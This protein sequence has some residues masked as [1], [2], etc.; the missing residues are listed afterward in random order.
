VIEAVEGVTA[1]GITSRTISKAE[2][3]ADIF[4][5]NQVYDS[6]DGLTE[7]CVPDAIMVLVSANQI[8]EVTEKLI[9]IGIPFFVEKPPGLVPDQT[10]TLAELAD[11]HGTKNMVG[12]NRRYYSSFHQGLRIIE[13]HGGLL[14]LAVEGHE[15]FWNVAGGDL[16]EEIRA[17][18]I[19]CNSTHTVDLLRF[20]GGEIRSISPHSKGLREINGDQFVASMQ[21]E[22]G[23]LGTYTSH[24]YSPGGWSATLFGDG[25]TVKFK[26]LET[27]IW[28]D[29]DLKEHEIVPDNVDVEF[30]PGFYSQMEGFINLVKT[31]ILKSPGMDLV[32]A[33]KTMEL[34]QKVACA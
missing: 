16:P 20:F 12:Y 30:K 11:R 9:P 15:R 17:N 7:K 28:I 29:N 14:G 4:Q 26:P 3:V 6:V 2:Q 1:A 5:I 23:A 25:V 33:L 32:E 22:L 18:W 34:A 31:H 8:F 13:Q 10:R 27:G 19:Y 24:W 21:F